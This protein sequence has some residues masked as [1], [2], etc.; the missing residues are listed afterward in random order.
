MS[1]SQVEESLILAAYFRG[2]SLD[3]RTWTSNSD[4]ILT[5]SL[6]YTGDIT[7][8]DCVGRF[9]TRGY[10]GGL[11]DRTASIDMHPWGKLPA[12]LDDRYSALISLLQGHPE[13]IEGAGDFPRA[14]PTFTSCRL[15]KSGLELA[16]TL[17]SWFPTKP[18]FPDWPDQRK[19]P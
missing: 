7:V 1:L 19:S 18:D 17:V 16:E 8:A 3:Q 2:G 5:L 4:Q 12:E 10:V 6:I 9:A 13:L 11:Y 15:T 14:F